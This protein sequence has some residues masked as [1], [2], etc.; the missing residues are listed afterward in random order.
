MTRK[1][2]IRSI[3]DRLDDL[4][5][6]RTDP[7]GWRARLDLPPDASRADAWRAFLRR[8]GD[9]AAWLAYLA[10]GDGPDRRRRTRS[11]PGA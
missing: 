2:L 9:E 10:A 11:T 6:Q 7:A 4:E 8:E 5:Q 3:E 1:R